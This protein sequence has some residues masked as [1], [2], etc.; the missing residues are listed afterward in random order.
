MAK[1]ILKIVFIDLILIAVGLLTYSY[2]HH[3]KPT[4]YNQAGYGS[5]TYDENNLP[6]WSEKF[7]DKFSSDSSIVCDENGYK[8]KNVNVTMTTVKKDNL[9]YY[10]ADIYVRNISYLKTAFAGDVYSKGITDSV[11]DMAKSKNAIIATNGDHYGARDSGILIRNSV[12]YRTTRRY[13]VCALYYD[14]TMETYKASEFDAQRAIEGGVYQTW[15][16]G[17]ALLD[18]NG[19]AISEFSTGIA[20]KNP[21][22]AIGYYEPGH[23]CLVLVDGRQEGYS[24]GMTLTE[25]A[26]LFEEM[27]CKRA[28]NLDGGQ[29]ANMAYLGELHNR[30]TRGGREVSDLIYIWD[31]AKEEE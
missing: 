30:P 11:A 31:D 2:F 25:L 21:G 16:F 22:C 20:G 9:C 4:V 6:D 26:M 29:S 19:K 7:A 3:V 18:R 8:S 23:Y 28:Y 13:Q 10:V 15:D 24:M 17:P 1:R 14:G 12:V 27:G 5:T